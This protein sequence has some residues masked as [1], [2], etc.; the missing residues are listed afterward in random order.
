MTSTDVTFFES[1]FYFE[2]EPFVLESGD[3]ESSLVNTEL[4]QISSTPL[5]VYK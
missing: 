5:Q 2:S 1:K 3:D 4:E